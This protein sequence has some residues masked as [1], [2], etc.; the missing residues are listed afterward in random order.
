[1]SIRSMCEI[2]FSSIEL[3]SN[4]IGRRYLSAAGIIDRDAYLQMSSRLGTVHTCILLG[5]TLGIFDG[6]DD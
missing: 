6:I 2:S 4:C 1:M 5:F 3:T